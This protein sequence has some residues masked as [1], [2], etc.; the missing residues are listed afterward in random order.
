[1]ILLSFLLALPRNFL[2]MSSFPE[3]CSPYLTISNLI[4]SF[5]KMSKHI[6][7]H[8]N[9]PVPQRPAVWLAKFSSP[10]KNKPFLGNAQFRRNWRPNA[11]W[12]FFF[13]VVFWGEGGG[14]CDADEADEVA[15]VSIVP[16]PRGGSAAREAGSVNGGVDK[17]KADTRAGQKGRG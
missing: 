2:N 12:E 15:T 11:D 4:S 1:M 9:P 5:S 16:Q 10:N 3:H 13:V 17:V 14:S 7:T 6:S 8:F